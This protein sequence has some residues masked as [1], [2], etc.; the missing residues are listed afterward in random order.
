MLDES[1]SAIDTTTETVLYQLMIDL[2]IWF[3]TISHR[4]SLIRY[5]SQELKLRLP[6]TS[7]HHH[8]HHSLNND[9]DMALTLTTDS[10]TVSMKTDEDEIGG[11]PSA[12][13]PSVTHIS[14]FV[15]V[16]MSKKASH[17]IRDLWK[18]IHLPFGPDDR[19]LRIQVEERKKLLTYSSEIFISDPHV[20]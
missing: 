2:N 7:H 6:H 1:T 15:E 16:K 8:H 10:E 20:S 14:E 3:V 4:P 18:L 5:H 19:R 11:R 17:E 13:S 12:T 9:Q